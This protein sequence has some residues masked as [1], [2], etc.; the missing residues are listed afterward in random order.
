MAA[1]GII[2]R[3]GS[4]MLEPRLDRVLDFAIL[5]HR[6]DGELIKHCGYSV[7]STSLSGNYVGNIVAS[8]NDLVKRI[9][10]YVEPEI[11]WRIT[12]AAE[13]A[14]NDIIRCTYSGYLG[15]DMMVYRDVHNRLMIYPA[16]EINLRMT[17][18]V[19]AWKL[20]RHI[21]AP[22]CTGVYTV[23]YDPANKQEHSY[24]AE[25]GRLVSG[26]VSMLPPDCR[27]K[28]KLRVD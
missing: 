21:I 10:A 6:N 1:S 15:V 20:A 22:D 17:M 26:I 23:A 8:D 13:Q 12:H 11:V 2:K 25:N 3:Q 19:V 24:V 14:L 7:F 16:V 4:V 28:I 27:F 18:G 5:Y 9:A